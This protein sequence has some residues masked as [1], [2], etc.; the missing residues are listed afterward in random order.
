MAGP[1]FSNL[2]VTDPTTGKPVYLSAGEISTV[3]GATGGVAQTGLQA[4]TEGIFKGIKTG[5][6]I[7]ENFQGAQINQQILDANEIQNNIARQTQQSEILARNNETQQKS[8]MANIQTQKLTQD[9]AVLQAIQS[10]DPAQLTAVISNP[11]TQ[12]SAIE[13]DQFIQSAYQNIKSNGGFTPQQQSAFDAY[14]KTKDIY[15]Q[16]P[17]Q[18]VAQTAAA[19]VAGLLPFKQLEDMSGLDTNTLLNQMKVVQKPINPTAENPLGFGMSTVLIAPNGAEVRLDDNNKEQT[20]ALTDFFSAKGN[21]QNAGKYKL[22][23]NSQATGVPL[24]TETKALSTEQPSLGGATPSEPV[25]GQA[26]ALP[27]QASQQQTQTAP[28]NPN[29]IAPGGLSLQTTVK[30]LSPLNN[31][32]TVEGDSIIANAKRQAHKLLATGAYKDKPEDAIAKGL[33]VAIKST[34]IAEKAK[35][36]VSVDNKLADDYEAMAAKIEA[37]VKKADDIGYNFGESSVPS[38]PGVFN[39][40]GTPNI[41]KKI[42]SAFSTNTQQNVNKI[43]SNIV[44]AAGQWGFTK[45]GTDSILGGVSNSEAER[46]YLQATGPSLLIPKEQN[47]SLANMMRGYVKQARDQ[48][49]IRSYLGQLGYD[50]PA[51]D[52]LIKEYR[53][54]N[55]A[56]ILNDETGYYEQNPATVDLPPL[57][58]VNQKLGI[59]Q[60][61]VEDAFSVPT[62]PVK[63]EPTPSAAGSGTATPFAPAKKQN[64]SYLP[65]AQTGG[66]D[67]GAGYDHTPATQKDLT[68]IADTASQG[69]NIRQFQLQGSVPKKLDKV[70]PDLM[71]RLIG[72]EASPKKG[73]APGVVNVNSVSPT[74]VRGVAQV[75]QATFDEVRRNN[76]ELRLTDRTNPKQSVLAGAAYLNEMLGQ[77][78]GNVDLSLAA[79]NAGPGAVQDALRMA[80]VPTTR[81]TID[82]IGKFLPPTQDTTSYVKKI[83][84]R[85]RVAPE[86]TREKGT[87]FFDNFSIQDLNPF[88]ASTVQAEE[89]NPQEQPTAASK[90]MDEMS[91]T[92]LGQIEA[93]QTPGPE[94]TPE[95]PPSTEVAASNGSPGLEGTINTPGSSIPPTT[96]TAPKIAAPEVSP[97]NDVP[98]VSELQAALK[99]V[100][101]DVNIE[102]SAIPG[103]GRAIKYLRNSAIGKWAGDVQ[104]TY[105]FKVAENMLNAATFGLYDDGMDQLVD[106]TGLDGDQVQNEIRNSLKKF[107]KTNPKAALLSDIAGSL[108]GGGAAGTVARILKG[109]SAATSAAGG[110]FKAAPI[111]T[112]IKQGAVQGGARSAGES[113]GGIGNAIGAGITGA[114]VGAVGG[115]VLGGIGKTPVIGGSALAGTAV[116]ATAGA[117]LGGEEGMIQGA[118]IGMGAGI[119]IRLSPPIAKAIVGAVSKLTNWNALKIMGV[120]TQKILTGKTPGEAA[121]DLNGSQ[122]YIAQLLSHLP[123][124]ELKEVYN[125]LINS[126]S[127]DIPVRLF[128]EL[129]SHDVD[130]AVKMIIQLGK[131]PATS[132]K[133][134]KFL[135]E[136]TKGAESR[137]AESLGSTESIEGSARN[138]VNL[139]KATKSGAAEDI[140]LAMEPVY[141]KAAENT[142]V[143]DSPTM[144]A[145]MKTPAIDESIQAAKASISK[146]ASTAD[147]IEELISERLKAGLPI[148]DFLKPKDLRDNSFNVINNARMYLRDVL[149]P[150]AIGNEKG[151]LTKLLTSLEAEM[152]ALSPDFAPAQAEYSARLAATDALRTG[153]VEVIEKLGDGNVMQ[154]FDKLLSMPPTEVAAVVKALGN[155][156]AMAEFAD[157]Y[158]RK[159]LDDAILKG[160]TGEKLIPKKYW[161]ALTEI[162]G[163]GKVLAYKATLASESKMHK[164]TSRVTGGSQTTPMKEAIPGFNELTGASD[165][166]FDTASKVVAAG[167]RAMLARSVK[168]IFQSFHKDPDPK[169]VAELAD[170]IML[171]A[172]AGPEAIKAIL[173]QRGFTKLEIR[174]LK[175]QI[176]VWHDLARGGGTGIQTSLIGQ[177]NQNTTE[178]ED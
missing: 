91:T 97:R 143:F 152:N 114:A 5:Q 1:D 78:K 119:A 41:G 88:A 6:N 111:S 72:A 10:A 107:R 168:A 20:K 130:M 19:G 59:S 141:Q 75:T 58:W 118:G 28:P 148:D 11:Q 132:A 23:L 164:A 37:A 142:P 161:N 44:A 55:P 67:R 174:N 145:L 79:Y 26:A 36:G 125:E 76:P 73:A 129:G 128:D 16:G 69:G 163:E 149:I 176:N 103:A 85:G 100:N 112:M 175:D 14:N 84:S 74:G 135:S 110:I 38:I 165:E 31:V 131:D 105:G 40:A 30:A 54:A 102:N 156:Q 108:I 56:V 170:T 29:N 42:A 92:E 177:A 159:R 47:L 53:E 178:K 155:P 154:A 43:E 160:N 106:L 122:A 147:N 82:D 21:L 95:N 166:P 134:I 162:V 22:D 136:R 57:K 33:E 13:N 18:E 116:G 104:E 150:N 99:S 8:I 49:A 39:E 96:A 158:V 167:P 151:R 52:A 63:T 71:A 17:L 77:F 124:G 93:S 126:K 46:A 15:Q 109:A 144:Q 27:P 139:I 64:A 94:Q 138:L 68:A 70:T 117:A 123:R 61:A 121:V 80:N 2:G 83:T 89:F 153:S 137:I 140:K 34:D 51:T 7:Y 146:T 172:E 32:N 98:P 127:K 87:G 35:K 81:A 66:L 120:M 45:M 173:K 101:E 9:N 60:A 50:V 65:E 169:K 4:A 25:T 115:T 62:T 90:S 171:K 3:L 133:A 86:E 24:Q 113:E 157:G 48:V 12:L